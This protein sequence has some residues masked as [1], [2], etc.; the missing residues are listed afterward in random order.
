L[1]AVVDLQPLDYLVAFQTRAADM[2]GSP[3]LSV[4]VVRTVVFLI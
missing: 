3:P 1:L 4:A 2:Q